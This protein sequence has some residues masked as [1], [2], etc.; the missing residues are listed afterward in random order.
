MQVQPIYKVILRNLDGTFTTKK[1]FSIEMNDTLP[2]RILI[3]A[4]FLAIEGDINVKEMVTPDDK[5]V[6]LFQGTNAFDKAG[7]R[8]Y[9]GDILKNEAGELFEVYHSGGSYFIVEWDNAVML[10]DE[11]TRHLEIVGNVVENADL[12]KVDLTVLEGK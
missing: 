7:K 5:D 6:Y 3:K 9:H 10:L 2:N 1:V 8:I 11:N 4:S 12:L